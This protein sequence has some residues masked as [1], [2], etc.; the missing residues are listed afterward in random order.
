MTAEQV[1]R[2][3]GRPVKGPESPV[4]ARH[5]TFGVGGPAAKFVTASSVTQLV[6]TV[7]HADQ[8]GEPLLVLAGGS[9]LL[10]SDLGFDGTVVHVATKGVEARVSGGAVLVTVQAGEVWEDLVAW[11]V[12]QQ[13]SGV[14]TLAGIP[15]LVGATPIQNVGAYGC[16]VS[17][18]IHQ[19]RTFDRVTGSIKTFSTA[20]CQF[21]YRDSIFKRTR[22]A[23]V[24]LG[25][26]KH[27]FREGDP[28]ELPRISSPT[29]RY[30]VL[31]VTF[32]LLVSPLSVPIGY[33]ELARQLGVQQGDRVPTARARDTVLELRRSK[34][35]VYDPTDHDSW[36]A[37]SFFTNPFLQ[38]EQAA[39]LPDDAPRFPQPDGRVKTSAAWLIERSGFG[40]GYG[41]TAA[42]LSNKHTLALTNRGQATAQDIVALARQ[43]RDGVEARFGVRLVPEP[44][45]VGL[46]V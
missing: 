13:W 31:E 33:A 25:T 34:G 26:E 39:T 1:F 5:T 21:G 30:L 10:I 40:K 37:G 17:A 28:T 32:R 38:P 46:E 7:K 12:E 15:G 18:T 22:F 4:L 45:L 24:M 43:V 41:G 44:V 16:D 35:M 6:E 27:G 11:A 9:N 20:D 36:S 29:G 3:A 2:T 23:G 14:E 19:V 42:T 8:A